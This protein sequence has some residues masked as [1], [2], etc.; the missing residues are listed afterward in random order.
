MGRGHPRSGIDDRGVLHVHVRGPELS[1]GSLPVRD[2]KRRTRIRRLAIGLTLA[3]VHNAGVRKPQAVRLGNW[4]VGQDGLS[5][6]QTS[7]SGGTRRRRSV[8]LRVARQFAAQSDPERVMRGL[9]MEAQRSHGASGGLVSQWDTKRLQLVALVSTLPGASATVG[10]GEGITGRAAELRSPLIDNDYPHFEGGLA[11]FSQAGIQAV[12]A[13]PLLHEGHLL[14]VIVIV[15]DQPGKQFTSDDAELLVMMGSI[16]ASTMVALARKETEDRLRLQTERLEQIAET[17]S[18]AIIVTDAEMR[19]LAWNRGAEQLYGWARQEVLGKPMPFIPVDRGEATQRLWQRVLLQGEVV[20]NYEEV[21]L[22]KDGR[23]IPIVA[24]ISPLRDESGAIVGV[25][26]I[27]KDLSALRELEEQRKVLARL[28]ERQSIAMALHDNTLQAL[29]GAVLALAAVERM[30]DLDAQQVKA[31]V[32]HVSVRLTSA[33][34]ELRNYILDLRPPEAAP[35]LSAGLIALV[36]E[37]RTTSPVRMELDL[38]PTVDSL[39]G[40]ARVEQLLA[41]AREATSNA[42]RHAEA[43]VLAIRLGVEDGRV[44]LVISDDGR[45]FD[46]E[47]PARAGR[48]GLGNMLERVRLTGGR[49][50]L[51][52]R[53]GAGA[54]VRVDLPAE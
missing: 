2:A 50:R 27:A 6:P 51:V 25:I 26:G 9:L 41:V 1:T 40:P 16:A 47:V 11:E 53:P 29:H 46:A 38:D 34:H 3:E 37:A 4:L 7:A 20:A 48:Q 23:R 10:L 36:E 31:A 13:A 30:P 44:Q 42:I 15:S 5:T 8:L 19:L 33:I 17:T 54:E 21:R 49:L 24:T 39:V 22:T 35:G 52:S 32:T 45:G 12:I 28:E 14:G 18:D 43:S